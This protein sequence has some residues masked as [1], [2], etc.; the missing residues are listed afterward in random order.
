[1]SRRGAGQEEPAVRI[2]LARASSRTSGRTAETSRRAR[3]RREYRLRS[4]SP[5]RR[6][7]CARTKP[8]F[9][10]LSHDTWL[11]FQFWPGARME[12]AGRRHVERTDELAAS[13]RVGVD[14]P[15]AAVERE[16]VAAPEHPE[17]VVEGVVL[18]HEDDDV[19]DLRQR[20]GALGELRVRAATRAGGWAWASLRVPARSARAIPAGSG[21]RRRPG[22][23]CGRGTNGGTGACRARRDSVA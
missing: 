21:R 12:L 15:A 23:R 1:M 5:S 7:R 4:S 22:R 20:V 6:A 14:R 16:A 18:H 8:S 3:S 13:S 9:F 19:L 10:P 11:A 17:V 2:R